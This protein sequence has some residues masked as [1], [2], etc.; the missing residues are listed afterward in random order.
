MSI[1]S[2]LADGV[3]RLSLDRADKKN[4]LTQGMYASLAKALSDAGEDPAVRVVVLRGEGDV[5]CAGNDVADFQSGALSSLDGPIGDFLWALST[6]GKPLIGAVHGAAV[7]IGVTMLLHCDLVYA[8]QGTKLVL[9]FVNLALVP[10]AASSLLLP[11]LMGHQRAAE[12]LLFGEPF[13]AEHALEVGIVNRVLP[14]SELDEHVAGRAR[15]LADKPLSALMTTKKLLRRHEFEAVQ[16]AIKVEG[17][18]FIEGLKSA[19]AMEAF[20]AFFERR[21][22]DFRQF[23]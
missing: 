7:G 12:L 5:W 8:A 20:A 3:L 17:E 11:G 23:S 22:A 21:D 14:A 19:E 13:T 10:E 9:P 18:F 4:A 15:A 6:F 2:E 16:T 1:R